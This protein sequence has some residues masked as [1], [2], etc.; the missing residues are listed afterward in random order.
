MHTVAGKL[1]PVDA[2]LSETAD[3]FSVFHLRSEMFAWLGVNAYSNVDVE[4]AAKRIQVHER[5]RQLR[6]RAGWMRRV[7]DQL[8]SILPTFRLAH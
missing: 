6:K 5:G 1:H 4:A 8:D 2:F 3:G 7:K